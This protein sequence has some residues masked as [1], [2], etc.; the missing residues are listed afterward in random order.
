[1]SDSSDTAFDL[2]CKIL[3]YDDDTYSI[4]LVG[5]IACEVLEGCIIKAREEKGMNNGN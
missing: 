3:G 1:M 4:D 2:L 5:I